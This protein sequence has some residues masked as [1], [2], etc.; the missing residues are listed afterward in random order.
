MRVQGFFCDKLGDLSM[1]NG[2]IP[3]ATTSAQPSRA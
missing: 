1:I 2:F 3:S